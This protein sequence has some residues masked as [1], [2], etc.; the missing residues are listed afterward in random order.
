[1]TIA[2]KVTAYLLTPLSAM[3]NRYQVE[4]PGGQFAQEL[5]AKLPLFSTSAAVEN[6]RIDHGVTL[7]RLRPA[8]I[9]VHSAIVTPVSG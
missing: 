8:R 3:Q 2:L 5:L 6:A 9:V 7:A 4:R 1:M